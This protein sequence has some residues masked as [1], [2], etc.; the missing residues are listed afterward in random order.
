MRVLLYKGKSLTS[1]AIMF[2]T[3]SPYSHAAIQFTGGGVVE[4]WRSG[5]RLIGSP[6]EGHSKGTIIDVYRLSA[7]SNLDEDKLVNF[8]M[9][10]VGKGY[11]FKSI[12]RFL[13]RREARLDDR[14]FCSELVLAALDEVDVHLL[15]INPSIASPRDIGISPYLEFEKTIHN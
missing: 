11:D 1:K 9:Q 5:V 12:A 2:Q 3:R 14:W 4:A 8:L 15:N 13:T 6:F 7:I 10:Q